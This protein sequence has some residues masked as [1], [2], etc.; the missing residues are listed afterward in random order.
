MVLDDDGQVIV[1]DSSL[2]VHKA[3]LE[4]IFVLNLVGLQVAKHGGSREIVGQPVFVES[5]QYTNNIHCL[6][7]L[8]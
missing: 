3:E 6:P 7:Y 5:R 8:I 1:D 2:I 4:A